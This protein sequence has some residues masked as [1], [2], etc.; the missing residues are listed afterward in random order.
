MLY[1]YAGLDVKRLEQIVFVGFAIPVLLLLLLLLLLSLSLFQ[2]DNVNTAR[3]EYRLSFPLTEARW[4]SSVILSR[5]R[6]K[7]I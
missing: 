7:V 1:E 3:K 2:N 4:S 6:Q 5:R